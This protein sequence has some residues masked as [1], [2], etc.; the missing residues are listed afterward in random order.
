[1]DQRPLISN[2]ICPAIMK[3]A[4]PLTL[5]IVGGLLIAAPLVMTYLTAAHEAPSI[6]DRD[7]SIQC[8][9][10]GMAMG[11]IGVVFSFVALF[12]SNRP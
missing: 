8:Q 5:L 7:L 1:M 6:L 4:I 10:S 2:S 12:R 3:T 11:V 9:L